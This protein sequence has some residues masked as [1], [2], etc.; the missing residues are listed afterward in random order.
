MP[1]YAFRCG[2]CGRVDELVMSISDYIHRQPTLFCHGDI[3]PR[4]INVVPALASANALA[5]ERHYEGLRASDG[6]PIDTRAKHRAYMKAH[7]L[8][9]IDD[10]TQTWQREAE[11]RAG[12]L[13]GD[14]PARAHDIV[15]AI[16][17]LGG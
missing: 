15:E 1:T 2:A 16:H 17:K 3:M 7:N 10:Y 5:S 13:A 9:T 6:T 11:A 8:T 12:R 4:Y 14:D